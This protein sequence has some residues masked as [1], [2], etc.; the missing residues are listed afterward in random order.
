MERLE[1]RGE[2]IG[3]PTFQKREKGEEKEREKETRKKIR[4]KGK[5]EKLRS[6]IELSKH[7]IYL[8]S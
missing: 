8:C 3:Y 5:R 6:G 4:E 7:F 1:E 2:E